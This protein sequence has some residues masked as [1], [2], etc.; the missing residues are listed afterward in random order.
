M[1][2]VVDIT[3][4]IPVY[5]CERYIEQCINSICKN[6]EGG[7]NYEIIC[8][9]DNSDDDSAMIVEKLALRNNR[10]VLIKNQEN[11]GVSYSRN[12]A[13]QVACGRYVW[14]VDSDDMILNKCVMPF[15][16]VADENGLD[17]IV[18]NYLSIDEKESSPISFGKMEFHL[19]KNNKEVIDNVARDP[20]GN[21]CN[22]VCCGIYRREFLIKNNIYFNTRLTYGEDIMF[23][24]DVTLYTEVMAKFNC[25]CYN[26]RFNE[27]STTKR[28]DK[29]HLIKRYSKFLSLYDVLTEYILS[30]RYNPRGKCNNLN[31][32]YLKRHYIQQN[33]ALLLAAIGDLKYTKNE[34]KKLK[35]KKI[36]PYSARKECFYENSNKIKAVLLYLLPIE[37]MMWL[38]TI[39]CDV[40]NKLL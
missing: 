17:W 30:G 2:K 5:N 26:Y 4:G 40:R 16:S 1:D 15:I 33:I 18:G 27:K 23:N 9:D 19:V 31:T 37:P 12:T 11:K 20:N 28:R 8:V 36:Y 22:G 14:F 38:L 35:I 3:F 10:I 13:L 32:L 39:L 21:V 29:E 24:F 7:V 34:L 6:I 25:A